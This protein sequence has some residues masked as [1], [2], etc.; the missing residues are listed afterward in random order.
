M[1]GLK[2][3]A[4]GNTA[5]C[6]KCLLRDGFS[7]MGRTCGLLFGGGIAAEDG[8]CRAGTA[9]VAQGEKRERK[10]K[11]KKEESPLALQ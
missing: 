3:C 9:R 4:E 8:L 10:E 6:R 5:Q 2:S 1:W 7:C 11:E